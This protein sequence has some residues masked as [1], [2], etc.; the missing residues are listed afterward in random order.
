MSSQTSFQFKSF[1]PYITLILPEKLGFELAD[2]EDL[3]HQHRQ[4][5]NRI[6]QHILQTLHHQSMQFSRLLLPGKQNM[7]L[8]VRFIFVSQKSLNERFKPV[9]EYKIIF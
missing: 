9:F 1:K 5:D 4:V 7:Y 3:Y 8:R 6:I 2:L